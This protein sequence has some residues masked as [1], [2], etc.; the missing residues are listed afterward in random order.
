[1]ISKPKYEY[2]LF[3]I[4]IVWTFFFLYVIQLKVHLSLVGDD[5]TYL[6]AAENIYFHCRASDDRPILIALIDGL[7]F[8]FGFP[9]SVVVNWGIFVNYCCWLST[10]LL[11]FNII[12][13]QLNRPIAFYA[14]LFFVFC[15][16]NLAIAF[17]F[18][19]ESIFIFMLVLS[20]FFA[21]KYF[22]TNSPH[23]ITLG[24]AVLVFAILVKPMSLGLVFIYG[25]FFFN[26]LKSALWNKF[27]SLIL[28]GLSMIFFQMYSLKQQYGD[29]TISYIDSITWYNY[30]GGKADCLK[31]GIAFY[32]GDNERAIYFSKF[33]S[34]E[35]RKI[36]NDDMKAQIKDNTFNLMKAYL[37]CIYSNTSKGCFIVSECE[38]EKQT[39]YFDA[40][41]FLFKAIS[42]LQ[43]IILTIVAVLL[44][45]Y[46]LTFNRK[47]LNAFSKMISIIILYVFFIS[48]ISCFQCDRFHIVF[49][50]LVMMLLA[51][52]FMKSTYKDVKI[53]K[54]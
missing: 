5:T 39:F 37:F 17:N 12:S 32:P 9:S 26:K 51:T 36:A 46:S 25:L 24:I 54:S 35:Q 49:Y 10:I 15:I 48:A 3:F 14:S 8:L 27:S 13:D 28:V 31:K 7:P 23:F 20:L 16:G 22:K 38:N 34:H 33:T 30:L 53:F 45:F 18:L 4:A 21:N 6:K 50:P 47:N 42:K 41:K 52:Y 1:M 2:L 11:I 29:Y 19:S 43:N 40:F 44:S